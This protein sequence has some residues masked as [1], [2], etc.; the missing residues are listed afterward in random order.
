MP[1]NASFELFL[2]SRPCVDFES[3]SV[4]DDLV[5][6]RSPG[7]HDEP[8]NHTHPALTDFSLNDVVSKLLTDLEHDEGSD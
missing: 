5:N 7:P 2:K 1:F 8:D 3:L 4:R 6:Q